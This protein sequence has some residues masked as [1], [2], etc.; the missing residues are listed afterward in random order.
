MNNQKKKMAQTNP[1]RKKKEAKYQTLL[2][3]GK[4]KNK[5]NNIGITHC[6]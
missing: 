2:I 1:Q 3:K 4:K 6:V 5:I